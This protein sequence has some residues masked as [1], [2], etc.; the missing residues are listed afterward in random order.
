MKDENYEEWVM[1]EKCVIFLDSIGIQTEF[2]KIGPGSFLPGFLIENGVIII[3]REAMEHPGDI[4]HEA[5][6]IAVVPLADRPGLTER[7][8]I[9]R[10]N[11]EA[12]EMMAIAWS[13]AACIHLLIDT[14]FVFHEHGYRDGSSY[15][16][17]SCDRKDYF[18]LPMLQEIGLMADE[19]AYP[20]LTR[21][22]RE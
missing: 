18:G 2:R 15:I 13:Y 16:R 17:E 22:L 9:K 12:E 14:R 4:L 20:L 7:S 1:F 6:H 11:R 10:K 5:G 3:D 21:W 8:M 19:D